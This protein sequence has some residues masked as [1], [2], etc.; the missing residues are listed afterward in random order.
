MSPSCADDSTVSSK[1]EKV[2]HA[3]S[4]SIQACCGPRASRS[5]IPGLPLREAAISIVYY[6]IVSILFQHATSNLIIIRC[7]LLG[8][9]HVTRFP[10][11][12]PKACQSCKSQGDSATAQEYPSRLMMGTSTFQVVREGRTILLLQRQSSC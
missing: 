4:R 2:N 11:L 1:R 5:E 10:P 8:F 12:G 6:G 7:V 3:V 9:H